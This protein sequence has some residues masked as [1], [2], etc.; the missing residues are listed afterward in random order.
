MFGIFKKKKKEEELEEQDINEELQSVKKSI[1]GFGKMEEKVPYPYPEEFKEKFERSIFE[2][3]RK[4]DFE[5]IK[6]TEERVEAKPEI[7]IKLEKYN[8]IL[9]TLKE[10]ENKI[11]ELSSILENLKEIKKKEEEKIG[12][13][14]SE[15]EDLK[16]KIIKVYESLHRE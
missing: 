12:E 13:W 5:N 10:I 3:E 15:I 7:Y 2:E 6:K 1:E 4:K 14:N 9:D 16:E 8:E 11:N